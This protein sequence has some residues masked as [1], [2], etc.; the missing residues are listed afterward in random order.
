[1]GLGNKYSLLSSV[2]VGIATEVTLECDDLIPLGE[3][4][5]TVF[6]WVM[7]LTFIFTAQYGGAGIY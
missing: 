3:D 7:Q 4:I 6:H 1:M 2:D 5:V